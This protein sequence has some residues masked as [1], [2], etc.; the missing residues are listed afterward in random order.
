MKAIII[1]ILSILA[2][3]QLQAQGADWHSEVKGKLHK[4][5]YSHSGGVK[6]REI[7][8]IIN[9]LT[10]ISQPMGFDVKQWYTTPAAGKVYTGR[11]YINFYRYYSFDKGPVQLST[12]H[13]K[14]VVFSYN[15]P[16]DLMNE[17]SIFHQDITSSLNLPV[18]FTDTFPLQFKD[19]DGVPVGHGLDTE[20]DSR[21]PVFVLNPKNKAYFRPVRMEE[22]IQ[23]F[24]G[25]LSVDISK[26]VKILDESLLT[27]A[28]AVK[29]PILKDVIPELQLQ[30]KVMEKWIAFL[31]NKKSLYEKKLAS[32]SA[33]E[34]KAPAAYSIYTDPARTMDPKGQ[35]VETITGH[36]DY[37]PAGDPNAILTKSVFTFANQPFD[38]KMPKA[39]IQLLVIFHPN[40]QGERDEI[41]DLLDE[42][43]F[44]MLSY[45]ALQAL[46]YK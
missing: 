2:C 20:Y 30:Q 23:F 6:I 37:E 24:I 9:K 8:D 10:C 45:K 36:I 26:D 41:A 12:S 39:A 32:M 42:K 16:G 43:F 14:T 38:T 21:V 18:M 44:P 33:E 25:K 5:D 40:P 34:R 28:E 46:M 35:P 19:I 4:A 22:Y 15:N 3:C 13:P 29:N 7:F 1:F 27:L 11:L 17:Q 31:K